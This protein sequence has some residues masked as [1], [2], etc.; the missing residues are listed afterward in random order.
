MEAECSTSTMEDFTFNN[1]HVTSR[2]YRQVETASKSW[3]LLYFI[4]F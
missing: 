2:E 1:P 3:H 4:F